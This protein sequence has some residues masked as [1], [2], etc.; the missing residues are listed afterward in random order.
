MFN[1]NPKRITKEQLM[2]I[3]AIHVK[4]RSTCQRNQVGAVIVDKSLRH[5]KGWG[6]NGSYS[7]GPNKCE[8][9]EPGNCGCVHGECNSL[10]NSRFRESKDVMFTTTSPCLSCTKM[11]INA[12]IQAVYYHSEYRDSSGLKLLKK[13]GIRVIRL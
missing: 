5:I 2:M 6:Y 7:G 12:G 13:S 3:F 10:I 8:S 11:I 9:K 4:T 1:N